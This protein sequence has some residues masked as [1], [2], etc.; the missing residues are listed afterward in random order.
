MQIAKRK[1]IV[2][3]LGAL[4]V[5]ATI[6]KIFIGLDMD[7][8]Y[9]V[10]LGARII[11]GDHLFKECWDLYQTTGITMAAFMTIYKFLTGGYTGVILWG[12]I[13][14]GIFQLGLGVFIYASLRRY[15]K[16]ADLAGLV[17]ANMLPRAT[18]N[19]EYGFLSAN[20]FLI[21]MCLLMVEFK[22]D[23]VVRLKYRRCRLA[24]AAICFCMGIL[25]YP[26]MIVAVIPLLFYYFL[27]LRSDS[28]TKF[29]NHDVLWFSLSCMFCVAVF[30]VCVF[31][32]ISPTEMLRN[33]F[34]GILWD[35]SHDSNNILLSLGKSFMLGREKLIQVVVILSSSAV[36]Y[37]LC[38]LLLHRRVSIVYHVMLLSSLM[39]ILLNVLK[40]RE[41]GPYGMQI[42][43]PLM[44]IAAGGI[45]FRLKDKELQYLFWG[46]GIFMFL[47]TLLGSNLSLAENGAFL[48]LS[49][50]AIVLGQGNDQWTDHISFMISYAS[51]ILL[52]FS[53]IFVKG[54]LVRV[55]VT[56]PA[57]VLEYR[58][59][60]DFGPFKGIYMYPDQKERYMNKQLDFINN[61][62]ETDI[63]LVLSSDPIYN[64]FS[65]NRFTSV[66]ALTT[67]VYGNQWVEYYVNRDYIQ[68]TVIFIDKWNIEGING[69]LANTPFGKCIREQLQFDKIIETGNFWI[70]RKNEFPR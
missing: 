17:V 11:Q 31:T 55:D 22:H 57:N 69:F 50:I 62:M 43:Y 44:V 24:F 28:E 40:I 53:L 51:V 42:R 18:L 33:I 7:E 12:R 48:Y 13:V 21:S 58:E 20:Y 61:V 66:T 54:Y 38:R 63:L 10:V 30:L 6:C 35:E 23:N 4:T 1:Y 68:P 19:L 32:Y 15:Y 16:N 56:E 14:T 59:K 46:M 37:V 70:L 45:L 67:P 5:L 41:S 8:N 47:G 60:A 26:T 3:L 29:I 27:R 49:V 52:V 34:E 39:L 25:S 64:L 65:S 9:I 36:L 2:M